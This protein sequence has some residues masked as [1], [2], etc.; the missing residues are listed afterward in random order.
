MAYYLVRLYSGSGDRPME[1]LIQETVM[2]DLV[3]K[4]QEGGGLQRYLA[5]ISLAVREQESGRPGPTDCA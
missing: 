4:L 2:N 5:V 3:P 1:Q